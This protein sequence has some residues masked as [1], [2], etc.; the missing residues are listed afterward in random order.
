MQPEDFLVPEEDPEWHF[1]G[2]DPQWR[3]R[4]VLDVAL[5]E[6]L[7][8]QP[9]DGTSDLEAAQGLAALAHDELV[10]Y[11]THGEQK[12]DDPAVAL[13]LRALRSVLRR[14][15]IKFELPFRDFKGFHGYWSANGMS[16]GGG[17]GA[18]RGYLQAAFEPV[19]RQLA[20]LED[21][22][23]AGAIRGVD[24][25]LKNIIFASSGPKPEIV[26]RDA[27]NNVVEITSNAEYCL[28]YDRPLGDAGLTLGE[29]TD[30]WR[31]YK[32]LDEHDDT[33]VARN[34]YR[35]L[36]QSLASEPEKIL[37]RT[38]GERYRR[39]DGRAQ[40]VLLPQVYLHYDPRTRKERLG[41]E[42][43][44]LR[45]RMDF[46]MLLPHGVRIVLEVDGKQHYAQGDAASPRLY[47]EMVAEDRKLR[48]KGYEVYRFGGYELMQPNASVVVREF[49]ERLLGRHN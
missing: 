4:D 38:Y 45:E 28:F 11:G 13:V 6:Q 15:S 26:L 32:G 2:L 47:S 36:Y 41:K 27:L 23:L 42:G 22:E 12:L 16:G 44:L 10:A 1:K 48:L 7:R 46:L 37:F 8:Q 33:E 31:T 17:W 29:L 43:A 40:T 24:G 30:W 49:F 25:E 20:E 14:L 21:R 3:V 35:R 9:L 19:F 18:R 5:V 34:L 39:D